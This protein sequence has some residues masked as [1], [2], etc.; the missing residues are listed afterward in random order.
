[1]SDSCFLN[2][3]YL[4][5]LFSLL[6]FR[7]FFFIF[8]RGFWYCCKIQQ[9]TKREKRI[10]WLARKR[11]GEEN[12]EKNA[13]MGGRRRGEQTR[14]EER[15]GKQE[16]KNSAERSLHVA[17][18]SGLFQADHVLGH[19]AQECC[20]MARWLQLKHCLLSRPSCAAR[21][22]LLCT[23]YSYFGLTT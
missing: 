2:Y 7:L 12:E 15:E 11:E 5:L 13:R 1:M 8:R 4:F 16:R 21:L 20:M 14:R 18:R 22:H 17:H 9:Q 23:G 19:A 6:F 3:D 10:T